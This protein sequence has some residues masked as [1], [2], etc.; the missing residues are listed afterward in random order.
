MGY[1][2]GGGRMLP[3]EEVAFDNVIS[4]HLNNEMTEE[5]ESVRTYY[6]YMFV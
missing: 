1:V 4:D 6:L 2:G 3:P 5:N